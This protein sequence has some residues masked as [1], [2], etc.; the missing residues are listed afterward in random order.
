ML[1]ASQL[2]QVNYTLIFSVSTKQKF[3][4]VLSEG[5][6]LGSTWALKRHETGVNSNFIVSL[7][8]NHDTETCVMHFPLNLQ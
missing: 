4:L 7:V 1:A 5:S 2:V 8:Q 3:L 6:T